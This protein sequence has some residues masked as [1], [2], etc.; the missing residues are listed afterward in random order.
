MFEDSVGTGETK[1]SVFSTVYTKVFSGQNQKSPIP[2]LSSDC[3][4]ETSRMSVTLKVLPLVLSCVLLAVRDEDLFKYC[5]V[6][7]T[8]GF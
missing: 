3:L 2:P 8:F 5:K 4:Q 6:S 1:L 7:L